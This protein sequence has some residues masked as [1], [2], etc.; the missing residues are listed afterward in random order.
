LSNTENTIPSNYNQLT[1]IASSSGTSNNHIQKLTIVIKK[2][3]VMQ[4][5]AM[6]PQT[7]SISTIPVSEIEVRKALNNLISGGIQ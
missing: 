1:C 4:C 5:A 7:T 3:A 2:S 6:I